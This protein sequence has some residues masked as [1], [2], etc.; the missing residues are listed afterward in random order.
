MIN[1]QLDLK[2]L[3]DTLPSEEGQQHRF[4]VCMVLCYLFNRQKNHNHGYFNLA[5]T[6]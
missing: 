2:D 6:F 1:V 4:R 5:A 3:K